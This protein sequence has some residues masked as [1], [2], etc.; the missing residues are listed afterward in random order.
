M[1]SQ[2]F[3]MYSLYSFR[4]DVFVLFGHYVVRFCNYITR[5]EGSVL[6]FHPD[7]FRSSFDVLCYILCGEVLS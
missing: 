6:C 2:N 3:L 5:F 7:V 4:L 1:E